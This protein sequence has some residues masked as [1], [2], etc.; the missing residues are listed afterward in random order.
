MLSP[1]QMYALQNA[2][3][4]HKLLKYAKDNFTEEELHKI[5]KSY[6]RSFWS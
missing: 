1:S 6:R 3:N 4:N 5:Y 2:I